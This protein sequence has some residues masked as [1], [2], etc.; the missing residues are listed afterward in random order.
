MTNFPH[1]H[2]Q[3]MS[4]REILA[5]EMHACLDTSPDLKQALMNIVRPKAVQMYPQTDRLGHFADVVEPADKVLGK[6]H[7]QPRTQAFIL[8]EQI[9]LYVGL[10]E[11]PDLSAS[12]IVEQ[13]QHSALG[14]PNNP[15]DEYEVEA[16]Q[17]I[18]FYVLAEHGREQVPVEYNSVIERMQD[19]VAEQILDENDP[20]KARA[21]GAGFGLLWQAAS[22]CD[23]ARQMKKLADRLDAGVDWDAELN[24]LLDD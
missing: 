2:N 24:H 7:R 13:I 10:R 14:E 20:A 12:E 21:F 8:G 3:D 1:D 19:L 11:F 9:G 23:D 15:R 18:R 17:A 5:T 16:E 6:D 22:E 4:M